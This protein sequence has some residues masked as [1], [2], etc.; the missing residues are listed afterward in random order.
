MVGCYPDGVPELGRKQEVTHLRAPQP[1]FFPEAEEVPEG[2]SHAVLRIFLFQLLQFRLGEKHSVGSDQ[3]VYWNARDPRRS[4]SPDLI[5]RLGVPQTSFGS[6]KTWEQGGPPDLAV[7]V[8]CPDEGD[9]VPWQEKLGRYH[10]LGVRELVRFDPLGREGERL[11]AWDRLQEDLVERRVKEDT[12]PCLL[13]GLEWRVLP[14]ENEAV[15][16]RLFDEEGNPIA[17]QLEAVSRAADGHAV[18]VRELQ[19]EIRRLKGGS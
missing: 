1:I 13:L 17:T 8:I 11:R 5:V 19:E 6:W 3:F 12:T 4:L 7:E 15:G 18:R 10:E 14:V 16:L 2:Y 9:G